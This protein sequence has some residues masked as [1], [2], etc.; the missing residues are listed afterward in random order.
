MD[1]ARRN[2]LIKD[3]ATGDDPHS[4]IQLQLSQPDQQ[5]RDN[6][7]RAISLGYVFLRKSFLASFKTNFTEDTDRSQFPTIT[8][9]DYNCTSSVVKHTA[10]GWRSDSCQVCTC[11][12][13][14]MTGDVVS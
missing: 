7:E 12:Y 14:L 4:T 10:D 6:P 13:A 9:A 8:A 2:L 5:N 11:S 3:L 1:G